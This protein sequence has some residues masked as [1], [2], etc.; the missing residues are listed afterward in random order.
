MAKR[1]G[2]SVDKEDIDRLAESMRNYDPDAFD[3]IDNYD[4]ADEFLGGYFGNEKYKDIISNKNRQKTLM[5]HILFKQGGG[6]DLEKD[7]RTTAKKVY[8]NTNAGRK[9]Y[10]TTG[11]SRSDL[12]KLD[13]KD[14]VKKKRTVKR[15]RREFNNFGTVKGRIVKVRAITIKHKSGKTIKR[16]IDA[17]GHYAKVKK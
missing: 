14:A 16:F 3:D 5:K 13:T 4:D 15:V 6:K 9:E 8:P 1:K 2:A 17:K 12:S 10:V 11:S 7:K